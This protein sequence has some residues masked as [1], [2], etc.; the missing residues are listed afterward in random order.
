MISSQRS[1]KPVIAVDIDDVI[2]AHAPAFIE[3]SNQKFGTHLTIE[4]NQDHWGKVWKVEHD[5]VEKRATEYH[6]SGY[7]A[8]YG[9]IDGAFEALKLLKKRF[10]LVILTT[11]RN[12]INHL[13]HEWI[14]KYYPDIFDD[15]VF[16]GF[17]DVPTKNSV[18]MT[19]AELAKQIGVEY[20]I[21]DQFKHCKAASD[22]GI[23]AILFG[24]YPWNREEKLPPNITQVKDWAGVLE[25]FLNHR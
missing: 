21:D 12:S 5:E 20:L 10:N 11:R 22:V 23:K 3:Y 19:K 9:I 13:T 1:T 17:F 25:F 6:E 15:I 14:N 7:I 2:A 18:N 8:T 16:A 24:D 4:D